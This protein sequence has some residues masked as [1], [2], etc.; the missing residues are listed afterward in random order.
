VDSS[1]TGRERHRGPACKD[2]GNGIVEESKMGIDVQVWSEA[3]LMRWTDAATNP[4]VWREE[5]VRLS[6][7]FEFPLQRA[8][9]ASEPL[10]LIMHINP[11]G[12]T[13]FNAPQM[14]TVIADFER[15]SK[16]VEQPSEQRALDE[17]IRVAQEC[18]RDIS[19]YLVFIGD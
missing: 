17:L 11:Y 10:E 2:E 1:A 16:Y 12:E 8:I 18:E 19:L 5:S 6:G 4:A 13:V 9:R 15:L 7:G 14:G 3:R